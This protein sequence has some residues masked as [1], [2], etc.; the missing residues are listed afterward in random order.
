MKIVLLLGVFIMW[1][2]QP[3]LIDFGT[4]G[5]NQEWFALNDG[6]MGGMSSGRLN[7]TPTSFVFEGQVS[8]E[9]NGGFA[10][11]RGPFEAMDLSGFSTVII[12]YRSTGMDF[13]LTLN[14]SRLWYRPNYKTSLPETDGKWKTITLDLNDFME[15]RVGK[16]TGNAISS[17]VLEKII[18][19]GLI[20]DEKRAGI[21]RIEVDFIK[22]S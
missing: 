18:R 19:L 1:A 20:S 11:A 12:K 3:L 4:Q 5:N 14:N 13:A 10:S 17:P 15:Y 21:Y 8:L 7:Y 22:F 2:T 9:N 6:V 16:A